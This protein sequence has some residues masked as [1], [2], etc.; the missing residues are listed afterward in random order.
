[1]FVVVVI[2]LWWSFVEEGSGSDNFSDGCG[3]SALMTAL[4]V[5]DL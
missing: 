5:S 4:A 1:M 2:A 3:G